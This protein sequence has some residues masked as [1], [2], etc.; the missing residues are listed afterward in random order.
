[1]SFNQQ[2]HRIR[3]DVKTSRRVGTDYLRAAYRRFTDVQGSELAA[4][5]AYRMVAGLFPFLIF[6]VAISSV[7][8]RMAG[9]DEP[10][11][12]VVDSMD[13]FLSD[14][15]ANFLQVRLRELVDTSAY[16]PVLAG[17]GATVWT[18]TI[19]GL[20]I[21]RT[22]NLIHGLE[23][24]RSLPRRIATAM[25]I[26]V[27]V[28][29]CA[30]LAFGVLLI[31]TL[32]PRGIAGSL[33]W[34]EGFGPVIGILRWPVALGVLTAAAASVYAIAPARGARIPSVTFGALCFALSWL[35]ASGLL[36]AY[37]SHADTLAATYGALTGVVVTVMWVYLTSLAFVA[38]AVL[39]S[40]YAR[41]ADR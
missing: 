11:R 8:V 1:M 16:L 9:G 19:G 17:F 37:V 28:G 7:V 35:V 21:I 38:G 32:N 2:G 18:G 15:V 3:G 29:L 30:V 40:E 13:S 20:S 23:E 22:L 6:A 31:G 5:L 33:G 27:I 14:P 26:G 36:V 39:D 41:H 25:A 4:A 10:A 24:H 12:R 34:A